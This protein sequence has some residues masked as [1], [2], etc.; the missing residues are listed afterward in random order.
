MALLLRARTS[1]ML[2]LGAFA[3]IVVG[4]LFQVRQSWA[5]DPGVKLTWYGQSAFRL[6]SPGG[7]VAL[8]DPVPDKLGYTMPKMPAD[9]VT[10]S[11]EHF[12]HIAVDKATGGPKVLRGLKPGGRQWNT[13]DETVRDVRVT[14]V[15]AWHDADNG[16]Q[17]GLNSIFV[18]ETGGVRIAHLGDLGHALS[19]EQVKAIG[20]V[21]V[22]LI[23]VGG[24]FTIDA[25]QALDVVD[26]LNPRQV[27]IPMHFKTPRMTMKLP[28]A[29]IEPFLA[30]ARARKVHRVAE[31]HVVVKP[32]GRGRE[33]VLL[34]AGWAAATPPA[35]P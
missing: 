23:P 26:Q 25:A 16:K 5:A 28:I 31:D 6:D 15:G 17:R 20:T 9:L 10:V 21:D 7:A 32:G 12:D 11:H 4:A 35:K 14:S 24:H 1:S 33:I 22:V 13:V 29:G 3:F 19:D 27:V 34:G 18:F 8:M 2:L 30:K